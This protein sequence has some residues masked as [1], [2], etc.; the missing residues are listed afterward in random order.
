MRDEL[1]RLRDELQRLS[2]TSDEAAAVVELDQT[3]VGRLSRMDAIRAQAMAQATANRRALALR[4]IQAA[5]ERLDAGE[6]GR[7]QRCDEQIPQ[8]RLEIDPTVLYCVRCAS[9]QERGSS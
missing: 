1:L 8:K 5:L 3:K 4:R 7:C 2:A 6:Y 9:E